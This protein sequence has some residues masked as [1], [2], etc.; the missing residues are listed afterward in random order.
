[1]FAFALW[2]RDTRK[3][4]LA[5]D[6]FGEKPLYYGL[7]N[8]AFMF[9]S[10][11]AALRAFPQFKPEIDRSAGGLHDLT[12]DVDDAGADLAGCPHR[13]DQLGVPV[14]AVRRGQGSHRVRA[15]DPP[16]EIEAHVPLPSVSER[17]YTED[18]ARRTGGMSRIQ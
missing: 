13:V 5:R 9:G 6:R 16:G 2:D 1:M 7:Q 14:D 15:E 12:G 17:L 4:F 18:P 8:G 3:L 11:L 10:E